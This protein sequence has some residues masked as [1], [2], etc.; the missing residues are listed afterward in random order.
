MSLLQR[1]FSASYLYALEPG[2]WGG[3][4]PVYVALAVVFATGAGACFFLLKRRQRALSPLTRALLAAEGLVCATGLGFTVA[5]FAR[6]PVLS[7]RVW[8][9]AALLSAGGVGAVYL[10]TRTR[11][12]D[13][14]GHQLRLLA[15]RFDADE[16][17]WPLATQ[18]ALALV[19]LGGLGLLWSWYR[20]PWALALP[21]LAVLLLP[22]VIP[23]VVRRG[24]VRLYFYMEALTPLFIA[25]AAMLWYN[26]FSYVLGVDL[27]RYEWFPYPDPWSA[28]F[29]VDAAV[30]AGVGYALL[31]QG[32]MAVVWL[33]WQKWALRILGASVLGLTMLWAGAEYLGHRTR[34]VTGSDPFCYA[35]MAVDLARTGS[36]L[37]RFPL[38]QTVRE[39]GLPVWPAVHVGYHPPIDEQGTAATVW[40]VGGALP[41][42]AG[43]LLLGEEGLYVT[44]PLMALLSLVALA[45]LAVEVIHHRPTGERWLTAGLAA[46]LLVTLPEQIDR[47]LVPMADA[48]AQLLTTLTVLCALRARRGRPWLWGTLAG[49]AF[50]GAYWVRHTQLLLA[51][52]LLLAAVLWS[53]RQWR[54]GLAFLMPCAAAALV[55]ALPDIIYRHAVFGSIFTPESPE[56]YLF[57]VEH[58]GHTALLMLDSALQRAEFGFVALFIGYGVYRLA[59]EDGRGLAVLLTT[60]AAV[61][62]I[63]LP[64]APLRWRDLLSIAPLLALVAA[65]GVVALVRRAWALAWSSSGG[66]WVAV[67]VAVLVL[68]ALSV[69]T[70]PVLARLFAPHR[71][72]FGHLLAQQRRAFDE[73]AALVPEDAVVGSTLNGGAVELYTGRAAV[74]P[75]PWTA[76]EFVR[77]VHLMA[78]EGR[79]VYLLDDGVE[80]RPTLDAA[81]ERLRVSKVGELFLPYYLAGGDS[82]DRF[83]TLYLVQ[84]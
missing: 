50:G 45:L 24:R 46:F 32:K 56:A 77:F 79:A 15:L 71:A 72:S 62:A 78:A 12:G 6:L 76:D 51:V 39:A 11:P 67:A 25:Y 42:A 43:Y 37:H 29:D 74:H 20:R 33:G 38:A 8:P 66:D 61:L 2:P 54:R 13:M 47:V 49:L 82:R 22:Q 63:H 34:G 26:L 52:S 41:L 9:F 70:R 17:P 28:T 31:V 1:L 58:V 73:L 23:Q 5:R 35:Q 75:A 30:W 68:M 80:M 48:T 60:V 18:I 3:L 65:Y 40:P 55:V 64:Y 14:I 21:S 44:T 19:H 36:P 16:V 59:R 69:R 7:A 10:L 81:R 4:F 27:T 53:E 84:S 57:G 83:V